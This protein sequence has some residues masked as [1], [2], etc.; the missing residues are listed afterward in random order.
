[1]VSSSTIEPV[2]KTIRSRSSWRSTSASICSM[3]PDRIVR[4][5]TRSRLNRLRGAIPEPVGEAREVLSDLRV[6]G[7]NAE[8]LIDAGGLARLPAPM[9]Q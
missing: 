6:A 1:M 4:G 5:A 7:E 8:V 9:W 2:S 3:R